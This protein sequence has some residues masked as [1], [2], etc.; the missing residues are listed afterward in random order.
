[1][2]ITILVAILAVGIMLALFLKNVN[3]KDKEQSDTEQVRQD[4]QEMAMEPDNVPEP[5]DVPSSETPMDDSQPEQAEPEVP[6]VDEPVIAEPVV[7]EPVVTEPI[8]PKQ[9]KEE[10]P[11]PPAPLPRINPRDDLPRFSFPSLSAIEELVPLRKEGIKKDSMKLPV[12]IGRGEDS[13]VKIIDLAETPNL[14]IAGSRACYDSV[15]R[16]L[17]T[18]IYSLLM[19]R[20]P[21]EVKFVLMDAHHL[22]SW[23]MKNLSII[24]SHAR[25]I[26]EVIKK[27]ERI[28]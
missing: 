22:I 28:V 4:V 23:V 2:L 18:V 17:K 14:F 3:K 27:N 8:E 24:I 21:S 26:A 7:E 11:E 20:Y 6:V 1:M 25:Q 19:T 12:A 13:D 9:Q 5:V 10:A 16:S 15:V